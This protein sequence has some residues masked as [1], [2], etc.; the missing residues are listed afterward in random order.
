MDFDAFGSGLSALFAGCNVPSLPSTPG[1]SLGSTAGS[2]NCSGG[3]GRVGSDGGGRT[4][5][6][7]Y[8][9]DGHSHA[10]NSD[11]ARA[12]SERFPLDKMVQP[13][14]DSFYKL[15][16]AL[17]GSAGASAAAV[18]DSEAIS[19]FMDPPAASGSGLPSFAVALDSASFNSQRV[20]IAAPLPMARSLL[21]CNADGCRKSYASERQLR[22][23]SASSRQAY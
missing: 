11:F 22:Y 21:T 12:V 8:G 13:D 6:D 9:F 18:T 20:S 2:G 7:E 3:I 23:A 10:L 14:E 19:N 4:T 5:G 17:G 1:A 16:I 15:V